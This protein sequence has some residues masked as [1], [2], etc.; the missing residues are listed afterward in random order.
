MQKFEPFYYFLIT[1]K[2][3]NFDIYDTLHYNFI[4]VLNFDKYIEVIR[5]KTPKK[6]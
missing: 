5:R 4:G 1:F 2:I 6:E 3:C